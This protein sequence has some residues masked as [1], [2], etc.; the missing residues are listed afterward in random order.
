ML[1]LFFRHLINWFHRH[2]GE[3]VLL[4]LHDN[5]ASPARRSRILAHLKQCPSCQDR[6]TQIEENWKRLKEWKSAASENSALSEKE[7]ASKIQASIHAWSEANRPA[8]TSRENLAT[9]K[10]EAN[11]Q[12]A[13]VLGVY[14]G[15]RA[16]DALL[17]TNNTLQFSAKEELAG[18]QSALRILIGR[19]SATAI[20]MKLHRI[21]NRM[22]ESAGRSS[23]S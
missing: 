13:A 17:R 5:E 19:K 22:P 14:L 12:I 20:E 23:V 4:S 6:L 3:S 11:R 9:I 15:R 21:M 16:A 7:L 10:A 2:P 18:A 8:S 1:K